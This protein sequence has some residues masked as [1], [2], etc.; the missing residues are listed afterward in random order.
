[1]TDP[2]LY[3]GPSNCFQKALERALIIIAGHPTPDLLPILVLVGYYNRTIGQ[4]MNNTT[5]N[6]T[7]A[8]LVPLYTNYS[9]HRISHFY[10]FGD[11]PSRSMITQ[12]KD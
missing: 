6:W 10:I 9:P 8:P 7:P 3:I 4:L 12:I 2:C 11:R 5:S 1:M